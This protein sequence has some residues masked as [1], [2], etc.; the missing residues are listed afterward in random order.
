LNVFELYFAED[1]RLFWGQPHDLS[2]GF[3]WEFIP[4]KTV[5]TVLEN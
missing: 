5:L 3:M 1:Q 2:W 4:V